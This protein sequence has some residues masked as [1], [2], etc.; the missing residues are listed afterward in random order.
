MDD[1]RGVHV[2][3]TGKAVSPCAPPSPQTRQA[4]HPSGL[5]LSRR[6]KSWYP[7]AELRVHI[8]K[9]DDTR[10]RNAFKPFRQR[11]VLAHMPRRNRPR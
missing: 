7:A 6:P 3:H 2:L 11:I 5:P 9:T 10:A 8:Q 1:T 4:N